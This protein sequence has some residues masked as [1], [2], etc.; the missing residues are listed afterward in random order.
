[1]PPCLMAV[2]VRRFAVPPPS[3]K[4]LLKQFLS[5]TVTKVSILV[6]GLTLH[7][8]AICQLLSIRL[9]TWPFFTFAVVCVAVKRVCLTLGNWPIRKQKKKSIPIYTEE[10]SDYFKEMV[11]KQRKWQAKSPNMQFSKVVKT[12]LSLI[13]QFFKNK[14]SSK[15]IF[16][17][18]SK[19]SA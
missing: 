18:I 2:L 16:F 12:H 4:H 15:Y 17:Y 10:L 14:P 3:C 1:M 5:L 11:L 8:A 9:F 6:L 19:L 13:Y 7:I